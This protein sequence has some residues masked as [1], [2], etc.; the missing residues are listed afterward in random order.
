LS[1]EE[2]ELMKIC[3]GCG[4]QVPE[5]RKAPCPLCGESKGFANDRGI[6]ESHI[7]VGDT[8]SWEGEITQTTII[9]TNYPKRRIIALIIMVVSITLAGIFKLEDEGYTPFVML[10]TFFLTSIPFFWKDFMK[11][12]Q[13]VHKSS[14]D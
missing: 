9:E 13:R 2:P 4:G 7:S 12:K 11:Q 8:V 10:A 14:E 1:D 3:R 6:V 5:S